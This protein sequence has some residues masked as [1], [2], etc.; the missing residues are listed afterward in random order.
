MSTPEIT[1]MLTENRGI[2]VGAQNHMANIAVG[3]QQGYMPDYTILDS[4]ANYVRP[5][6]IA[7]LIQAP[8]GFKHLPD[9]DAWIAGL[10][11]MVER[12]ATRI[13]GLRSTLNVEWQETAIGGA[14]EMQQDV[15]NVTRERSEPAFTWPEKYGKPFKTLLSGWIYYLMGDP[16]TKVPMVVTRG[17]TSRVDMVPSYRGA[18]IMFIE[19]DITHTRVVEAWLSTNMM[20]NTSGPIEGSRDLTAGGELNEIQVTFS[21]ITQYGVGVNEYAQK[22]LDSLALTNANPMNAPAFMDAVNADVIK[23]EV[24]YADQIATANTTY[25]VAGDTTTGE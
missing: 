24:G 4:N 14:G 16:N 8:L 10:K 22:I 23:Q 11:A 9:S 12:H 5:N 13:E 3:G 17:L 15:S 20:P 18:T 19:P 21:A 6:L 25:V 1:A 2:T 7:V